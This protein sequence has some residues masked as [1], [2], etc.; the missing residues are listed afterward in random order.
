VD[1]FITHLLAFSMPTVMIDVRPLATYDTENLTFV[2]ADATDLIGIKN[3]SIESLSALCS[4]EHFGLGRYGD[5]VDPIAYLK[6]FR[7]MERVLCEGG[8]LYISLPVDNHNHIVFNSD[9]VFMPQYVVDQ[10]KSLD[11]VEF[12]LTS[13]SGLIKDAPLDLS[14]IPYYINNISKIRDIFGLFHFRKNTR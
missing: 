13:R 12:S 9:R 3:S 8:D 6:A 2:C 5:T 4:V 14:G 7:S 1:G 11:L 10:F